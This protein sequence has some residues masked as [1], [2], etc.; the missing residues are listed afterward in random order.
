MC[1]C[2]LTLMCWCMCMG[3]VLGH[4]CGGQKQMSGR[5]LPQSLFTFFETRSF[6]QQGTH[7]FIPPGWWT[8][9]SRICLPSA[10]IAEA[11]CSFPLNAGDLSSDYPLSLLPSL[12][13]SFSSTA[14]LHMVSLPWNSHDTN[15]GHSHISPAGKQCLIEMHTL[16]EYSHFLNR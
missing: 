1:V 5:W 6:I 8:N 2:M 16:I 10:R 13:L 11:C 3:Y 12:Y 4:A 7:P 14:L 9:G 15:R